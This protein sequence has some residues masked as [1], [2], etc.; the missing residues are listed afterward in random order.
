MENTLEQMFIDLEILQGM[1]H[2]AKK[3]I[4]DNPDADDIADFKNV[5]VELDNCMEHV[6]EGIELHIS[7]QEE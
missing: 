7:A 6:Q 1:M 4:A 3:Y 5:V 2:S